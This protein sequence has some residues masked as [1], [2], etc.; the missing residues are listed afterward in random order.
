[1]S[2]VDVIPRSLAPR[3]P[4]G[5]DAQALRPLRGKLRVSFLRQNEHDQ[6]SDP[7]SEPTLFEPLYRHQLL[8]SV[9]RLFRQP[10]LKD[11]TSAV[12]PLY[13]SFQFAFS[14]G[15]V[16]CPLQLRSHWLLLLVSNGGRQ[17]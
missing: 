14:C 4:R 11:G 17:I 1:M 8:D 16:A 7:S 15:V 2:T 9:W 3:N 10:S 13:T 5:A 6:D 12:L